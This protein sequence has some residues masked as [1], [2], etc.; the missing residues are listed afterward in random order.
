[1]MIY[2][3]DQINSNQSINHRASDPIHQF[4]LIFSSMSF[5]SLFSLRYYLSFLGNRSFGWSVIYGLANRTISDLFLFVFRFIILRFLFGR[6]WN[7]S[8]SATF[9][10]WNIYS[11]V[12]LCY[13]LSLLDI[14]TRY[15]SM[16]FAERFRFTFR[17]TWFAHISLSFFL[18]FEWNAS[19]HGLD[20]DSSCQSKIH[21]VITI[22]PFCLRII[23]N[24]K[25]ENYILQMPKYQKNVTQM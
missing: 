5:C 8:I 7:Q 13:N 9:W 24:E 22:A 17:N 15:E 12:I 1:M 20:N 18:F 14:I 11:T 3:Q 19:F 21:L 25:K 4:W 16:S 6:W 2:F 23:T 10:W